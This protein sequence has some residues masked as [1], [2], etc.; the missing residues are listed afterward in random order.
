MTRALIAGVLAMAAVTSGQ[1]PPSQPRSPD[2]RR[3]LSQPLVTSI[4]TADP[5]AHVFGGRIYI[6][7]SHDIEGPPLPDIEPFRNSQGNA[8]RMRDYRVL[9]LDRPGGEVTVHPVALDLADVPWAA[10]QMWAPDAAFKDGIYYL[11]FPA[12]DRA[13]AFRIGVAESKSP[14]GPFRARPEPI[15]GSY[16]ID[17][18]VFIDDDGEA[19]MYFGGMAGGQLQKFADG[20]YDPNGPATDPRPADQPAFMPKVVRMERT[21]LEFA[22]RPRDARILDAAGQTIL[23]GDV[24]RR[25]FEAAWLHKYRGRYYLSYSTGENRTIGYAIGSSP[26]GPFRHQGDVLLP[27]Q[28]WTTHHSIVEIDGRW[29]LF[30]ADS[31]LSN[32]T[33]LRNVKMTELFY[34]PDGTIRTID[35]FMPPAAGASR[36]GVSS[37]PGRRLLSTDRSPAFDAELRQLGGDRSSVRGG[38]HLPVD[39]QDLPVNADVERPPD[40][41]RLVV[42]DDAVRLRRLAFGVAQDR[43]VDG[44][45]TRERCVDLGL[46]DARGKQGNVED[47]DRLAALTERPALRRST[48]AAGFGKPGDDDRPLAAVVREPVRLAIRPRQREIR[49][50]VTGFETKLRHGCR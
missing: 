4:Y 50:R 19:Y 15:R 21:M 43:V 7:A 40:R 35:P 48:G 49:G 26:Y 24:Q 17:P 38:A 45:V 20:V 18:S 31:Q 23:R 46:V 6:Y 47:P 8:F 22:E 12:K 1:P 29:W 3:Y 34:N 42:A 10:R 39:V 2:G 14:V 41:Q 28:G 13:G 27:V 25:F 9:S 36:F 5:S 11:Y 32:Q 30:Y 33:W 44:D 16:S 37:S